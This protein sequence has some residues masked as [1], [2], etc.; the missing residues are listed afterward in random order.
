MADSVRD[1]IEV[2]RLNID[3]K[4]SCEKEKVDLSKK[5]SSYNEIKET[6]EHL[7]LK[8]KELGSN[9]TKYC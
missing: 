4:Q 8:K 1:N 6:L 7:R 5:V 3:Y 2:D 9:T